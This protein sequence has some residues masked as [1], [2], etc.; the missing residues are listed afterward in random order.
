[1]IGLQRQ[2]RSLRRF[3]NKGIEK[4][5]LAKILESA[6]NIETARNNQGQSYVVI[7]NDMKCFR[8]LLYAAANSRHPIPNE[9]DLKKLE[10]QIRNIPAKDE[11]LTYQAPVAIA[12]LKD[13]FTQLRVNEDYM[14]AAGF[15]AGLATANMELSANSMGM[16]V[17][18]AG[19]AQMIAD[20]SSDIREF[21]GIRNDQKLMMLLVLGYPDEQL[22]YLRTTPRL[23]QKIRWK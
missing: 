23:D 8:A 2:R 7:Q 16:G 6:H 15:E 18:C 3:S 10:E 12:I 19:M 22:K 14:T 11:S 13:S 20:K 5:K 4:E 17:C 21:L 1:M 9:A